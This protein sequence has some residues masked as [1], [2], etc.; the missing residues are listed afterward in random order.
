MRRFASR[1]RFA[2]QSPAPRH[3]PDPQRRRITAL[4]AKSTSSLLSTAEQKLTSI[5]ALPEKLAQ[6]KREKLPEGLAEGE[7]GEEEEEEDGEGL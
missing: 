7:D 2:R 3:L 1:D 4:E 6:A 5:K